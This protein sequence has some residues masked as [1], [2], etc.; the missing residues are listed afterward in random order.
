MTFASEEIESIRPP[1]AH[2][3]VCV[4]GPTASGKSSLAQ[5]IA[6]A[7]AGEVVSADSMQIYRGMDIGTGK[8][9][10]NERLVAHHGLDIVEPGEAFSAA[11]FQAYARDC[12]TAIDARG[13]RSILCGG[14]GFYVR[15][16][17]D[18]YRF[19]RGEQIDNPIREECLRIAQEHGAQELWN[20]LKARD[21]ASADII[22]ANDVKRV[23]RAFELLADGTTYAAQ[24][25]KLAHIEPFYESVWIGLNVSPELLRERIDK[26]VDSMMENGLVD[27]VKGLLSRG[28]RTALTANQ[29]IGYKEIVAALDG[30]ITLDEAV[31]Q[32]KV[33]THQYA[34][35]QR[36]WFRKEKRVRW[37]DAERGVDDRL[38]AEALDIIEGEARGTR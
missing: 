5:H 33:A 30:A 18:D 29:A 15:A 36:T 7:L 31:T 27:E 2:P 32:I 34:K 23:S 24:K 22:P 12:F 19:P 3:I 11:L 8:V 21:A 37:I 4:V 16:A 9:L 14:T 10:P 20:R 28:L 25:E 35:R 6:L 26:R 17:I 13:S 38:V 1:L